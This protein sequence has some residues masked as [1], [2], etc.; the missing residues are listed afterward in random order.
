MDTDEY[1]LPQV[2]LDHYAIFNGFDEGKNIFFVM[3]T[4]NVKYQEFEMPAE[5]VM[6]A[7]SHCDLH[8]D[9][10][11][12]ELCTKEEIEPYMFDKKELI[13]WAKSIIKFTLMSQI[14]ML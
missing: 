11:V 9:T 3:D 6:E 10:L 13:W 2:P 12:Y 8:Y 7:I 14:M 5:K 4:D 1:V